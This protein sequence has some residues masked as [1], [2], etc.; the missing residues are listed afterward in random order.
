MT[1]AETCR[2]LAA[3]GLSYQQVAQQLGIS[4]ARAYN[5]IHVNKTGKIGRPRTRCA[6]C[7][8]KHGD[9]HAHTTS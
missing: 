2:A 6:V 1:V 9:D 8:G 5:A 3:Q 4:R 7:G